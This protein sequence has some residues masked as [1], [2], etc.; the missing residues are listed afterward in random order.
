MKRYEM[1]SRQLELNDDFDVI[2]IGG[3]PSG[4]T[5]AIAAA[6]EGV[7]TLLIEAGGALG[8][9]GT[10]GLVPAWCP[11][12]DKEKI[13]YGGL[14]QKIFELSKAPAHI[15]SEALDWQPID[16]ELLKRIYENEVLSSGAKILFN[17]MLCGAEKNSENIVDTIIISSKSGLTAYRAKIF[18]DCTG[19]GDLAVWAGAEFETGDETGDVQPS[20]HCFIISNVDEYGFRFGEILHGSNPKSPIYD[21]IKSKKYPLINSTHLCSSIIGPGTVGFNAGHIWDVDSTDPFSVTEGLVMGRNT[22]AEYRDALAEFFPEAFA[23]SFLAATGALMGIRESRRIIGDYVLTVQDYLDRRS[24]DDEI[25]RNSYFI[26][27]H[28]NKKDELR[29]QSG[30]IS[31]DSGGLHYKKGESHGI[32]YRC[33]TPAGLVNVLVA[34]RSIS[35][36][37]Q[38]QGSVR[39]MPVCLCM[40]EAAGLAAALA[41]SSGNLNVHEVD[42]DKLRGRLREEG[43]Y[44]P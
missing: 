40:G 6:R 2:V 10:Q 16:P 37:R 7:K 26:D 28:F 43:A 14:A 44:L 15:N 38:V 8:G 11:F 1:K 19:D 31:I 34:G 23:N 30:E 27:V 17:A 20:S 29:Q 35:C 13:I 9:M 32:P 18:I 36:D 24:F 41:V 21:I 33:L 3:G 4:C 22:A 5:A 12:S 42:T 25:C 39:V